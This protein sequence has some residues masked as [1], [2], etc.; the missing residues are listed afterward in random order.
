LR[1]R[2]TMALSGDPADGVL[3]H[4]PRYAMRNRRVLV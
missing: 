2:N 1:T 4:P 3:G